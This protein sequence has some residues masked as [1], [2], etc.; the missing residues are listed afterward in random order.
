ME[1]VLCDGTKGILLNCYCLLLS[2]TGRDNSGHFQRCGLAE[3]E[4]L[5]YTSFSNQSACLAR[6]QCLSQNST[7]LQHFYLKKK[8]QLNMEKYYEKNSGTLV[9]RRTLLSTEFDRIWQKFK[10]WFVSSNSINISKVDDVLGIT[11]Q[12]LF[13][14]LRISTL[15]LCLHWEYCSYLAV[16]K[17]T[18]FKTLIFSI[19]YFATL[20]ILA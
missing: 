6:I 4:R 2:L 7:I 9:A 1:I 11:Q 20:S 13:F 14:M 15:K 18:L 19:R 8:S 10:V 17:C 3:E 5:L 16:G 12:G